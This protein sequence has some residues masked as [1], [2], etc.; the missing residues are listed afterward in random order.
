MNKCLA[1]HVP[2]EPGKRAAPNAQGRT[3]VRL[4]FRR[5]AQNISRLSQGFFLLGLSGTTESTPLVLMVFRLLGAVTQLFRALPKRPAIGCNVYMTMNRIL[6]PSTPSARRGLT[7]HR[8]GL[9]VLLVGFGSAVFIWQAQDRIDRQARNAG[10]T[11]IAAAPLA[12]GDSRRETHDLELYY[13][14]TGLLMDKWGRW[15]EG[16]AHGKSLAKTIA[17]LSLVGASGCFFSAR[18]AKAGQ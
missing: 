12:A 14:E 10:T 13:G 17:V 11:D 15:F 6:L 3:E 7:L 8:L 18:V 9:L 4:A 5:T 16:L 2:E 1:V